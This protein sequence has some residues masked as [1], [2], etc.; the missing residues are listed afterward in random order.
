LLRWRVMAHSVN[1]AHHQTGRFDI[2]ASQKGKEIFSHFRVILDCGKDS[3]LDQ[4]LILGNDLLL[5]GFIFKQLFNQ[6]YNLRHQSV[7]L[8]SHCHQ[9]TIV[10]IVHE[11]LISIFIAKLLIELLDHNFPCRQ[12]WL[13]LDLAETLTG[14]SIFYKEV[15]SHHILIFFKHMAH[16]LVKFVR[17]SHYGSGCPIVG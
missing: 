10:V 16:E 2:F 15:G 11:E 12:M 5:E 4:I 8:D 3:H 17:K 13:Q 9:T 14:Y 6:R 1:V 7:M